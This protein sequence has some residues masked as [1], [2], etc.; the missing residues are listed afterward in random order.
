MYD[1]NFLLYSQSGRSVQWP[2][3]GSL[4]QIPRSECFSTTGTP[5]LRFHILV[6]EVADF[7]VLPLPLRPVANPTLQGLL[8][9]NILPNADLVLTWN[10]LLCSS[11]EAPGE[12]P[13]QNIDSILASDIPLCYT[14]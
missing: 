1:E 2:T 5:D 4:P 11:N 8:I 10:S 14:E 12:V 7:E 9:V 13:F 6:D 3:V